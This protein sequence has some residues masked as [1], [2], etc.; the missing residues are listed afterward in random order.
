MSEGVSVGLGLLKS[1]MS[2]GGSVGLG[3][4]VG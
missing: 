1:G 3:L 2:E 4:R